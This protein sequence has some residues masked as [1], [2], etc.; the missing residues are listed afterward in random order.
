MHPNT[1]FRWNDPVAVRDFVKDISFANIF[2]STPDGPRAAQA[3][4]VWAGAER[5]WF[6]VARGNALARHLDGMTALAVVSGPDAYISPDWYG[7][8]DQVPTWNYISVEI[9]GRCR[10]LDTDGL[11]AVLDALSAEHEARLSPKTPW[12][13]RKMSPGKFESMLK[14]IVGFEME[15]LGIRATAKLGQNKDVR[16]RHAA[17][18]ALEATGSQAVAALM[19]GWQ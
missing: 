16:T 11:V 7:I 14:A 2:A 12:T 8:D 15:V 13:R 10:K 18:D 17:A 3:P 5:L 19:K 4:L 9:E 1:I 6:H